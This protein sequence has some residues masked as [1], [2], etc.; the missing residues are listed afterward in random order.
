MDDNK[1]NNQL[2]AK[3]HDVF[4][5]EDSDSLHGNEDS[6]GGY[7]GPDRYLD[8]DD[9]DLQNLADEEMNRC[10]QSV[11]DKDLSVSYGEEDDYG[12]D[13]VEEEEGPMHDD[14]YTEEQYTAGPVEARNQSKRVDCKARVNFQVMNDGSCV[15]TK[16]ILEH[17]HELEPALSRFLPCHRELSKMVKRSL[18]AHD[19]AGLRPSKSIRLL[20]VEAGGPERMRCT[21]KFCRN[22]ILQQWRLRTLS[23]DAAALHRFFVDMQSKDEIFLIQ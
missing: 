20:E 22:Y 23:S 9:E 19:I 12:E 17:N 5:L 13:D 6:Y 21:P 7:E 8:T 15:V 3:L 4:D 11:E 16:V 1:C 18:V 10:R 14:S 2:R